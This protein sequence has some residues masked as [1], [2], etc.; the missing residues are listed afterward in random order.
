[1]AEKKFTNELKQTFSYIKNTI[2]KEYDCDK[3]S[4]EYLGATYAWDIYEHDHNA[5]YKNSNQF[6]VNFPWLSIR[7]N[8]AYPV[9]MNASSDDKY[10]GHMSKEPDQKGQKNAYFRW[11]VIEDTEDRFVIELR[12]AN[13][14]QFM[15]DL[16]TSEELAQMRM[17]ISSDVTLRRFQNFKLQSDL[18]KS[19]NWVI[20]RE[21]SIRSSGQISPNDKGLLTVEN[22]E[23]GLVPIQL[24]IT[25][26]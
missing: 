5:H 19:Y 15:R 22:V 8:Q 10:P 23:I 11:S 12:L 20:E 2:L 3:I 24:T 13:Q 16:P 17:P 1:M 21:G 14:L 26:F 9:F 6:A 25:Q 7:R 18:N 4:T